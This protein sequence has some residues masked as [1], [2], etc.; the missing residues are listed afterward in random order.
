MIFSSIIF[1]SFMSI[2]LSF[3]QSPW[4]PWNMGSKVRKCGRKRGKKMGCGKTRKG[5]DGRKDGK[6]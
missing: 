5:K 3:V 4:L 2:L 1:D 6:G